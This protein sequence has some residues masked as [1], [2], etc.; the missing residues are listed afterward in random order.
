MKTFVFISLLS[1]VLFGQI[2]IVYLTGV[3]MKEDTVLVNSGLFN[4][5]KSYTYEEY[6]THKTKCKKYKIL[7]FSQG[8][9][10]TSKI[11][12]DCQD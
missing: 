8:S 2:K 6:I 7:G 5:G 1:S 10:T 9:G 12:I 11:M 4:E 3:Q